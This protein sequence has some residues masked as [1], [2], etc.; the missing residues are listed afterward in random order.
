MLKEQPWCTH[1]N[2][3]GKLNISIQSKLLS[4][5][6]YFGISLGS[7]F[8]LLLNFLNETAID[9]PIDIETGMAETESSL[10]FHPLD[11][12]DPT[13]GRHPQQQ[14]ERISE[15]LQLFNSLTEGLESSDLKFN[16]PFDRTVSDI[17]NVMSR[18]S[19]D[20][21]KKVFLEVDIGTSYRQ[22][23]I[24]NIFFEII[25]RIGTKASVL[26]T[27]DLVL[28]KSVKPTT[29]VQLLMSLP[30]HIFELSSDLVKE[31]EPLLTLG[32]M[33]KYFCFLYLK[34]IIYRSG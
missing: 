24:R 13:G 7:I 25:P 26:L 8:R 14:D 6:L 11:L 10:E 18:M 17:I 23:T 12:N 28:D 30:F 2:L 9:N 20:S 5:S 15:A 32:K 21:L 34:C 16:E 19:L 27:K 31:C 3:P 1:S 4:G 22:E 33:G 29:A